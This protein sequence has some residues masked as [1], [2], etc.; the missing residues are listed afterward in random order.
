[1][2]DRGAAVHPLER[3]VGLALAVGPAEGLL[4]RHEGGQA[5]DESD[6]LPGPL[7]RRGRRGLFADPD[8]AA[9]R[10]GAERGPHRPDARVPA[11]RGGLEA[12]ASSFQPVEDGALVV[13]QAVGGAARTLARARRSVPF[14]SA[15]GHPLHPEGGLGQDAR[16][17]R[18]PQDQAKGRHVVVGH[19]PAQLEELLGEERGIVQQVEDRP[20]ALELR[21]WRKGTSTRMPGRAAS[22]RSAGRRYTKV[23]RTGRGSATSQ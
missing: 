15:V 3:L 7:A 18:R 9:G 13:A 16:R 10:Q 11:E 8:Q 14:G 23:L 20:H 4:A 21:R 12:V 6:H 17:Q 2:D 1:V 19:P 22:A 5:L